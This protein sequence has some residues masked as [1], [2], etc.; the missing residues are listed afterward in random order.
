MVLHIIERE[1]GKTRSSQQQLKKGKYASIEKSASV[2][3]R[4]SR[5]II[6]SRCGVA[7]ESGWGG[8]F[9]KIKKHKKHAQH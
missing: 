7:K 2:N 4:W 9:K 5:W 3:E 6:V 1:R 8:E